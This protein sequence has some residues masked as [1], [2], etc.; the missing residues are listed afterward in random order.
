MRAMGTTGLSQFV[1]EIGWEKGKDT[2]DNKVLL[3]AWETT[4]VELA[5]YGTND[6]ISDSE[7][8]G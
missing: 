6:S 1:Q 4:L 5:A 8:E 3:T 7:E 2:S